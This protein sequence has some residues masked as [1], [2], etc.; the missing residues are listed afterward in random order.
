[1]SRGLTLE[2]LGYRRYVG[3][4]DQTG[5][6][7]TVIFLGVLYLKARRVQYL[8]RALSFFFKDRMTVGFSPQVHEW[9]L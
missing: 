6:S 4:L 3:S 8:L 2:D 7:L 5:G 1:M 9:I